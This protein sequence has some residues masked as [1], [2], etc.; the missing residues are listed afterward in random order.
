MASENERRKRAFRQT[1]VWKTFRH[2]IISRDKTDYITGKKLLKGAEV[3]HED[4]NPEHYKNLDE[5]NFIALNKQSHKF[6]HWIYNYYRTD[7]NI[8]IRLTRVLEK[9]CDMNEK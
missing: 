5:D 3:H 4:L 1:K 9:M 8:I 2:S 7:K 6:L